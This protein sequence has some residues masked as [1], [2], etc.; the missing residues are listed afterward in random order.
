MVSEQVTEVS[1]PGRRR[2]AH[3]DAFPGVLLLVPTYRQRSRRLWPRLIDIAWKLALVFGC[4]LAVEWVV[5]R[6]IKR[7]VAFLESRLP[8]TARVPA[9][10]LATADP[11]SSVADVTPQGPICSAAGSAWRGP[12]SR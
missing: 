11:P 7:P 3:A 5:F 2:R 9:Q 1:Q 12:G 4:A 6:L 10:A 8:Q